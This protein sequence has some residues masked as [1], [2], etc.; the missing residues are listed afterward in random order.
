[1]M[2]VEV[3]GTKIILTEITDQWGEESHTFIGRPAMMNW[4][5]E[6]FSKERFTGSEEEWDAIMLAFSE[7]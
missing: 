5:K 6:R 3:Q 4:A 2:N 7:V 1:M